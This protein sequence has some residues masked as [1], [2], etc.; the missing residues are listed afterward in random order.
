MTATPWHVFEMALLPIKLHQKAYH[1]FG[2]YSWLRLLV[3]REEENAKIVHEQDVCRG[4]QKLQ[5]PSSEWQALEQ[6]LDY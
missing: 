5:G 1:D 4:F 3:K 6:W 2:V